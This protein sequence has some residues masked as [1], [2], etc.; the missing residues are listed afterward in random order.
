MFTF[1]DFQTIHYT[2]FIA[3]NFIAV[4]KPVEKFFRN[5]V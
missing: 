4:K 1:G 5:M 2:L 3:V